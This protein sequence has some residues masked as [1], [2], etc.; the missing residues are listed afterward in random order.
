[1][2]IEI[3]QFC[4]TACPLRIIV[5][6]QP[7]GV[8]AGDIELEVA[9]TTI[10]EGDVLDGTIPLTDTITNVISVVGGDQYKLYRTEFVVDVSDNIPGD[11]IVFKVFIIP[12]TLIC[13]I[14]SNI[15]PFTPIE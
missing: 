11:D 2:K 9:Y 10:K 13:S 15:K 5:E 3:P 4:C 6:W 8:V 12:I 7:D 14:M 1:M